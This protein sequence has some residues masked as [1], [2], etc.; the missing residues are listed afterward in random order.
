MD[1]TLDDALVKFRDETEVILPP[2]HKS[3]AFTLT[4]L[5][6]LALELPTELG[7]ATMVKDAP[8]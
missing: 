1:S 6:T 5:A 4:I 7:L 8:S 3:A 2:A